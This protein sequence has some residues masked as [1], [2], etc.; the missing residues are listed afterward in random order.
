M[1]AVLGTIDGGQHHALDIA[2]DAVRE[3]IRL[4]L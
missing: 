4:L 1:A 2:L 3:G